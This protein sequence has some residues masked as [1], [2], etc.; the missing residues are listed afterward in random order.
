[1][2]NWYA[3]SLLALI[4]IGTQRFLYKVSAERRCNTALT[5]FTFMSTVTLLSVIALFVSREPLGNISRLLAIGSWNSIAFV[6]A[7]ITHI[8]ALKHIPAGVVYP[9]IR[10]NTGIVV[11]FSIITFQDNLSPYQI[12]GILIS[13]AIIIILRR[14]TSE[15]ED[16]PSD[17]K[18]GFTLAFISLF[19][20][21]MA[22][23][24][25]KFAALYTNKIAFI[26]VSY[27]LGMI[28]SFGVKRRMG[29]DGGGENKR[30]AVVIGI[31]MGLANFAG[32]YAFL[33]ALSVGS[34]AVIGSIMGLHFV[35]A[36]ILSALIFKEKIS[37]S[38]T[39]G[40]VLTIVS[41]ILL[42]L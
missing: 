12:A 34:L 28:L 32:F 33:K 35:I 42:R 22:I 4:L 2:I 17:L 13:V 19:A 7:T 26:T 23:I 11:I 29:P 41:V 10:L 16:S 6:I 21:A 37:T 20:G 8:E 27:G 18:R 38:R 14:S 5:T 15:Q 30:E 9:I 1:M 25:S 3:Y 39:L 40:I 36:I 24:S 31:V